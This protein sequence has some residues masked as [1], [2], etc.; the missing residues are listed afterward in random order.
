VPFDDALYTLGTSHPGALR[1]H[2]YPGHLRELDKKAD[3][4]VF[5]D[6][7]VVD[8]LRDRERGVPRYCEFRRH[9]RMSVPKSFEELTDNPTW[10]AELK[11]IY[12]TVDKVDLV[13]GTLV[14]PL[15]PGFAFSD[16]AFRIFILMATRRI[17]SDRFFTEDFTPEVYTQVGIDWINANSMRTVLTRHSP[18]L[19][20]HFGDVRNVFFP[21]ASAG[22]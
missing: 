14:E 20:R 7:G 2:N 9:L 5:I 15:P 18:A 10:Q 12:G 13:V 11:E 4:D 3:E 19:A 6:L 8:I 1:L 22:R 17:K 21:W 16:T